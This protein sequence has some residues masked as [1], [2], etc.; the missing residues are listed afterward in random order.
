MAVKNP[1]GLNTITPY[2]IVPHVSDL[3]AFLIE[4]FGATVRG[5]TKTRGDG[6]IQH[7][8]V[9]IGESV[10]MLGEPS[11][12]SSPMPSTLYT[13]VEDC[14]ATYAK[15]LEMGAAS[16]LEPAN[17]PHGDRYGGIRDLSGNL[18]WLVTHVGKS[19]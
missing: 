14:D 5:E 9:L 12:D 11:G 2:L 13:Y 16:V 19:S 15:A 10:V 1:F 17:Y 4:L 8:E 3:V 18:W 7:V 6:T